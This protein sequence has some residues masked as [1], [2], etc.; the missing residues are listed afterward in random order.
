MI[1]K[2]IC[3][4]ILDMCVPVLLILLYFDLTSNFISIYY[5]M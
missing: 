4:F 3:E 1:W 5:Y 2:N